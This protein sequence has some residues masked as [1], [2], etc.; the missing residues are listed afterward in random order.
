MA[1]DPATAPPTVASPGYDA[2]DPVTTTSATAV[3][4]PK[5][6]TNGDC[7]WQELRGA[8][9]LAEGGSAPAIPVVSACLMAV[10][11]TVAWNVG[12]APDRL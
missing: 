10:D 2:R 11:E 3:G 12:R 6:P 9:N 4:G 1:R 5:R 7:E 8:A